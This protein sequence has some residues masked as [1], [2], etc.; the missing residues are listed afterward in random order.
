[1][2]YNLKAEQLSSITKIFGHQA[3]MFRHATNSK[4]LVKHCKMI[5]NDGIFNKSNCKT[6][7][8]VRK[9]L[10]KRF[11]LHKHDFQFA[12]LFIIASFNI[13]NT[14]FLCS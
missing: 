8:H 6:N 2:S 14:Q 13:K 3:D 9:R 11:T 1:M 10:V 5:C 4:R 12:E 7:T